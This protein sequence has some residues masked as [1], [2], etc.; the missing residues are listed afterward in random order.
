MPAHLNDPIS[1]V[2]L[3]GVIIAVLHDARRVEFLKR[4]AHYRPRLCHSPSQPHA[5]QSKANA[6]ASRIAPC[7]PSG[8]PAQ[9]Q[10]TATAPAMAT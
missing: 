7:S 1:N 5:P 9:A 3:H 6:P 2:D 10:R 8:R 4:G